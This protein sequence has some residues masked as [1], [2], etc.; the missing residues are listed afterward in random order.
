MATRERT[1]WRSHEAAKLRP[2]RR[3]GSGSPRRISTGV[4]PAVG[5]RVPHGGRNGHAQALLPTLESRAVRFINLSQMTAE[6]RRMSS[7]ENPSAFPV[8]TEATQDAIG[9]RGVLVRLGPAAFAF[10]GF[11]VTLALF[12]PGLMSHDAG[13]V[14]AIAMRAGPPL[15]DWQSP[16]MAVLW[17]LIDPVAPGPGSMLLLIVALYWLG[18]GLVAT[19]VARRSALIAALLIA[20][21]LTPPALFM[22]GIIWR[23]ML[24]AGLWLTAAG[25]TLTVADRGDALGRVLRGLG[26]ALRGLAL[27][28]IVLG[29]LLRPNAIPAGALLALYVVTPQRFAWRRIAL[30]IV[31]VAAALFVLSQLT[32]YQVLGAVRQDPLHS[33]FVFDLAGITAHSGENVFPVVWTDE[34]QR[35]LTTQCRHDDRWDWYWYIPPCDFVMQRLEA[36][37]LFNSPVIG[38]AWRGAI[39]AH[40][41]AYLTHRA[42]Y[43]ATFLFAQNQT[44]PE[45]WPAAANAGFAPSAAYHAYAA[46][47]EALKVTPL[48][49]TGFW[50]A[51]CALVFA[52]AWPR[53][54]RAAGAFALA[55]AGSA[56]LYVASFAVLGV[57]ADF[58]YGYWAVPAALAAAAII[59]AERVRRSL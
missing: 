15:G 51:F 31:P 58:R 14:L 24:F 59:A 12:W 25:L 43:M 50:L 40:P 49:R 38:E 10:A 13:W 47:H 16:V 9:L 21:A 42:A 46:A 34:Q 55:T 33:L 27:A 28:L 57:S 6:Y 11:L 35:M 30:L 44:L 5:M 32:Y 3:D 17:R 22:L 2:T 8:A 45:T 20:A 4:R 48:F 26:L 54:E 37:R 19:A 18:I 1:N 56:A 7:L 36:D 29:V 52:F 53:R 23:D 39:L 41:L